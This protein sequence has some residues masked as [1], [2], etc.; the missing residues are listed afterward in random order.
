MENKAVRRDFI[1]QASLFAAGT[2]GL[3]ILSNS[4]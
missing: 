2:F 1:K 4:A 3:S